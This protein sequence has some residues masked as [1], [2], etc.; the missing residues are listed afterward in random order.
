MEQQQQ[1]SPA[2]ASDTVGRETLMQPRQTLGAELYISG[3]RNPN[4]N[5]P[6]MDGGFLLGFPF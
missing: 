6:T 2:F 5:P 1:G 4:K 3:S